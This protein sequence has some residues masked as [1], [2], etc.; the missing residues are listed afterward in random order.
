MI[1]YYLLK[2]RRD[3]FSVRTCVSLAV[4]LSICVLSY[5]NAYGFL[6]TA[7]FLFA[8]CYWERGR[9]GEACHREF[10]KKGFLIGGLVFA[11]TGWWFVR[12]Y[13]LYDGDFLGLRT[14]EG[15]MPSDMPWI[16]INPQGEE[17]V[18]TREFPWRICSFDQTGRFPCLRALWEYWRL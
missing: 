15:N 12:N 11:L 18:S 14:Q 1:L 7:C 10:W 9:K 2:G 17:T 6:L 8:G 16:C 3:S 13:M 4:S 5:Y